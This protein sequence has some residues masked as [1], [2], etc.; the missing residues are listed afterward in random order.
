MEFFDAISLRRSVRDFT[1][2][3][4]PEGRLRKIIEAAYQAPANDHFRDWHYIVITDQNMKRKALGG[5]P[6]NLT[7]K[8]VDQMRKPS[9]RKRWAF[10]T[11]NG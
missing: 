6:Q 11:D 5:V 7:V 4:I 3:K 9:R 10:R 1:G 2:E 8:D